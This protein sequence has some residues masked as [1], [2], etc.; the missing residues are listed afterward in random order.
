MALNAYKG[1]SK[2]QN[3]MKA[4]AA[5]LARLAKFALTVGLGTVV[6]LIAIPVITDVVGSGLWAILA[7]V[8]S[9]ATLF[10]VLV[11]FGWGTV[12]PSMVASLPAAERPQLFADS[13]VTRSYL[14]LLT[15][16]IMGCVMIALQPAHAAFVFLASLTY[17]LPF[18][19]AS[20][21]FIGEAKP[22]RL[23]LAD[24]LPQLA[25][26][27]A[28]L[29]VLT[30]TRDL[31]LMVLTQLLFSLFAVAISAVVVLGSAKSTL[32]FDF[33]IRGSWSRM[34]LQRH[35]VIT[36]A[37]GS[38][39]VNLPI[40]AVTILI[41]SHL[42][43]YAF[44]DRL[45]RYGAVAFSPVLQFIQGWI[46]EGGVR[47]QK[48]RIRRAAQAAPLIGVAG[49]L[50]LAILGPFAAQVLVK[51][52]IPFGTSLSVPIGVAFAAVALSQVLG[53]ACLVAVGRARDLARSTLIGAL[54]GAPMIVAGA[55]SLGV[56][57]V[58]WAVAISEALVAAYQLVVLRRHMRG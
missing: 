6:G 13:L 5:A 27:V 33:S 58:A 41:P 55:L 51:D 24:A 11:A 8:Q 54:A 40:L 52:P 20:W 12:G 25:G 10:G 38:L 34:Q 19:G 15:A 14:Y 56:V 46:P 35:G 43:V 7:L 21:Y 49:G 17:L 18:L 26:T 32:S 42:D 53:L 31:T 23:F 36:A 2:E 57:G 39:Y 30:N 37:T 44:A 1:T 45:F 16:P 50:A 4:I 47:D 28:G 22:T 48:H 29:F 3:R 9:L